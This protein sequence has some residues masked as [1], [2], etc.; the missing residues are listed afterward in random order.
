MNALL[1]NTTGIFNTATGNGALYSNTTGSNNTAT[2]V[3]ALEI[4]STSN[5]TADGDEP[6]LTTPPAA[7]IPPRE[8]QPLATP[9]ATSIPPPDLDALENTNGSENT[10]EGCGP[11]EQHHRDI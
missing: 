2:G 11:G 5:N 10:A 9:R 7:P 1:S 8:C 3:D 4:N 6:S